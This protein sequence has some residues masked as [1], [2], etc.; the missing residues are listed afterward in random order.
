MAQTCWARLKVCEV[1]GI[2]IP[3]SIGF[4]FMVK[5]DKVSQIFSVHTARDDTAVWMQVLR[6]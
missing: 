1:R 4:V 5:T 3:S 6:F 2:G